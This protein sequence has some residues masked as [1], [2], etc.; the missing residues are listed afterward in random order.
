M[1]MGLFVLALLA[2]VTPT[3]AAFVN[4]VEPF[5]GT[6]LDTVTWQSRGDAATILQNNGLSV[7]TGTTGETGYTT[8]AL[9]IGAGQG[10]RATVTLGPDANG[11]FVTEAALELSTANQTLPELDAN[12]LW[13]IIL[14]DTA[15]ISALVGNGGNPVYSAPSVIN[16]PFTLE[17]IRN[18]STQARFNVYS[19]NTFLGGAT[20]ATNGEPPLYITLMT[21]GA[22]ATFNDVEVFAVPEPSTLALLALGISTVLGQR[23]RERLDRRASGE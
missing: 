15:S 19:Q 18:T 20:M 17:I 5:L 16:T 4:G 22:S 11:S 10:V 7:T 3:Q 2:V 12:K 21:R 8:K 13:M 14:N 1:R 6:T 23:R 9:T